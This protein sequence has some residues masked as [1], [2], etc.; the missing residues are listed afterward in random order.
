MT[1]IGAMICQTE[2]RTCA[3]SAKQTRNKKRNKVNPVFLQPAPPCSGSH[4]SQPHRDGWECI[5]FNPLSL[6]FLLE[7]PTT[8]VEHETYSP[9]QTHPAAP[10]SADSPVDAPAAAPAPATYPRSAP[11]WSSP[12]PATCC[13]D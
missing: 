13:K 8:H 6:V 2:S 10:A 7:P 12:H 1:K 5:Q 9:K 3:P 4:S 11:Y